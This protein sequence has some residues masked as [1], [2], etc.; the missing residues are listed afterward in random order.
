MMRI[1]A[2]AA[3]Q[4]KEVLNQNGEGMYIRIYVSGVG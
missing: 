3:E 2:A 4:L 1:T